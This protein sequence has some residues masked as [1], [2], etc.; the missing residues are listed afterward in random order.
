MEDTIYIAENKEETVGFITL[1]INGVGNIGAYVRMVAVAEGFRGQGIGRKMIEYVSEIASQDI[2]NLFLICSVEN[3]K[4]QDFYEKAGFE[5]VG[6]MKD[7]VVK[8]HD[9]ILYRKNFGTL[10]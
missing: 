3:K 7:L 10:Y 2:S 1:R 8:G 6:V 9:E 4:A 5:R